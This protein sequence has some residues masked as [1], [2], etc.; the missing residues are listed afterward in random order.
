MWLYLEKKRV[1]NSYKYIAE[2][3]TYEIIQCLA[4]CREKW[5]VKFLNGHILVIVKAELWSTKFH[6]TLF[7][8]YVCLN[9]KKLKNKQTFFHKHRICAWQIL[10]I[11]KAM[12]NL[13]LAREGE[14]LKKMFSIFGWSLSKTPRRVWHGDCIHATLKVHQ[15]LHVGQ[16]SSSKN[17]CSKGRRPLREANLPPA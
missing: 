9:N 16:E 3:F 17:H 7:S 12:H 6:Y 4:G 8:T 2:A 10:P 13:Y 5:G 15:V 1:L 14:L 11:P